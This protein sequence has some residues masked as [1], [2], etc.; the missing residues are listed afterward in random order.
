MESMDG[1][2]AVLA[3]P[4]IRCAAALLG[5]VV[6]DDEGIAAQVFDSVQGDLD[7]DPLHG[8]GGPAMY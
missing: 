7:A 5:E 6:D 1:T 4:M 3:W 2:G 8:F